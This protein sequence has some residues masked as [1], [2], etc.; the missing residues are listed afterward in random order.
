MEKKIRTSI[1]LFSG[2]GGLALGLGKA[3]FHH[4]AFVERDYHSCQTLRK[5]FDS[6]VLEGDVRE[7]AFEGVERPFLVAGGPPCQPFSLGGKHKAHDDQR[8]MFPEAIRVVRQ[9]LPEVI[10]FENV[11]GLLRKSFQ[12]YFEYTLRSLANPMVAR[13]SVE[14]WRAHDLVLRSQLS[15]RDPKTTYEVSFALLNAANFGVPQIRERVFIIGF[16]SDLAVTWKPPLAT[17]S[18]DRLLWEQHVTES[19][20]RRHGISSRAEKKE[21]DKLLGQYGLLEPELLPWQT[22]RDKTGHLQGF[23]PNGPADHEFRAGAKQYAGHTGSY[24][25]WPAKTIKAGAHGVPGGENML[26]EVDGTVRYFSIHEAKLIQTFPSEF[27]LS[28]SWSE[29][30]RQIG[31]AVPVE[32]ALAVGKSLLE[33]LSTSR[34]PL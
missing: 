1:E 16:R 8:D 4:A 29:S 24:I 26:R 28:G 17:H 9:F 30:L 18:K 12:T 6:V 14:S 33:S 34:G 21:R 13:A 25:D 19:Y 7:Q 11:K 5:N 2:A 32:L 23:G 3:G 10:L 31:N 22:V 20:W 15:P 27:T